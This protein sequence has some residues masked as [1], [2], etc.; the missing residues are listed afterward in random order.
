MFL[1]IAN[2]Q[3]FCHWLGRVK[4]WPYCMVDLNIVMFEIKSSNIRFP[5]R[6]QNTNLLVQNKLIIDY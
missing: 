3:N 1:F 5:S 4:Y 2:L 6:E